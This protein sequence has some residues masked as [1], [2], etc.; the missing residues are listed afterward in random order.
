MSMGPNKDG[1]Y[2]MLEFPKGRIGDLFEKAALD[3]T[4]LHN[5]F[6]RA[7]NSLLYHAPKITK[8]D[9]PSFLRYSLAFIHTLHHHHAT[10]EELYFPV[11]EE[12]LGEGH[13]GSNVVGHE[14]FQPSFNEFTVLCTKMAANPSTWDAS[15]FVA[16]IH[17]F[18][19]PLTK[20]LAE[21]IVSLDAEVLRKGIKESD[22]IRCNKMVE[23][24]VQTESSLTEYFL[25]VICNND[26]VFGGWL[27][28]LPWFMKAVIAWIIVPLNASMWKYATA[29]G[30]GNLK[31]EFAWMGCP[32]VPV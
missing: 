25:M 32:A 1:F 26:K 12:S 16:S 6:I 29:D 28:P 21:E 23:K 13:M 22:L 11:L 17:A 5:L 27:I 19:K 15:A 7:M 9:V 2:D 14:E 8:K 3:M 4:V 20:H 30:W 10:E 31:P 18:A 24:R